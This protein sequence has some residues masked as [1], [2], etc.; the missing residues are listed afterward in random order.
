MDVTEPTKETQ[1]LTAIDIATV[2][3]A[4]AALSV[5]TVF[6]ASLASVMYVRGLFSG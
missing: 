5:V 1:D 4:I 3:V 2:G 6:M